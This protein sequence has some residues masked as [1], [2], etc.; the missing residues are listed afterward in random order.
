ML[1]SVADKL[2]WSERAAGRGPDKI[3]QGKDWTSARFIDVIRR[4]TR[5]QRG[6]RN[7]AHARVKKVGRDDERSRPDR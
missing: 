6:F 5:P 7:G 4:N 1:A 3:S 2:F